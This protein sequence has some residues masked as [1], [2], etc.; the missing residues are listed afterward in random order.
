MSAV[1]ILQSVDLTKELDSKP[2]F[3]TTSMDDLMSELMNE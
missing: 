2:S 3:T 1:I